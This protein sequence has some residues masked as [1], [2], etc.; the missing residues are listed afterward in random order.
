MS[1]DNLTYLREHYPDEIE[2]V[3]IIPGVSRDPSHPACSPPGDPWSDLSAQ[4]GFLF[5]LSQAVV[6]FFFF[7]RLLLSE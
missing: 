7:V 2:E 3:F 1:F 6:F 5:L 4:T